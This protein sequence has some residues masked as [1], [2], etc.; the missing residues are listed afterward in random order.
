VWIAFQ[1]ICHFKRIQ[2]LDK[3][4]N[5]ILIKKTCN[6]LFREKV[7]TIKKKKH[8]ECIKIA[9]V[10]WRYTMQMTFSIILTRLA[11]TTFLGK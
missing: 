4:K 6:L 2:T 1:I 9:I 7:V 5:T 3:K 10:F 11:N 8:V